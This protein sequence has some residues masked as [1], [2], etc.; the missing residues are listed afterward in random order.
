[1]DRT[2]GHCAGDNMLL[3]D[4]PNMRRKKKETDFK[5]ALLIRYNDEIT[6]DEANRRLLSLPEE[7]MVRSWKVQK[8][9]DLR[10]ANWNPDVDIDDE[11]SDQ[12]CENFENARAALADVP[13]RHREQ[14]RVR[15]VR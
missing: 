7:A 11:T 4:I 9:S 13:R 14:C 6:D 3:V 10:P 1:M 15:T 5:L 2:N 8:A 12:W